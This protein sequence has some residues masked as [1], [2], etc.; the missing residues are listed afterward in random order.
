MPLF[1]KAAA[2]VLISE[3]EDSLS[4]ELGGNEADT[5]SPEDRNSLLQ[6][7]KERL[8][9][10]KRSR[11]VVKRKIT[12]LLKNILELSSSEED[13]QITLSQLEGVRQYLAEVKIFDTKIEEIISNCSLLKYDSNILDE[14]II[15]AS[16]YHMRN[17]KLLLRMT[18]D[19]KT[20]SLSPASEHSRDDSMSRVEMQNILKNIQAS[21]QEIKIPAIKCQVFKGEGDRHSFRSFL[22]SFQNI[23]GVRKDV[24]DAAK[25]QYLKS[26][27][28][29]N[30]LKDIEHLPN[31]D[32]N[33]EVA[34]DILKNLY[35]DESY[36]IDSLFHKIDSAPNLDNK[37]LENIPIFLSEVRANLHELKEFGLNFFDV[38]SA[39]CKLMSHIIVDKLPSNFLRELKLLTQ[40]EY[41]SLNH[42]LDNYGRVLKSTEKGRVKN[43]ASLKRKDIL[44]VGSKVRMTKS[45]RLIM[46]LSPLK[47]S[48]RNILKLTKDLKYFEMKRGRKSLLILLL[49]NVN[50]V[51]GNIE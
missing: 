6:E 37:N 35:L 13:I 20:C 23:Y 43:Q 50:F 47:R 32:E 41:P 14:E 29:G 51:K 15:E 19:Q 39:G 21:K 9:P 1:D 49:Q 22:L 3:L 34:L 26:L 31:V 11:A 12:L 40:E 2:G 5:L 44:N 30:A 17:E 24:T 27:L 7:L 8:S 48:R 18:P 46:L 42:I 38:S 25:L 33:L 4:G 28:E 10:V 45:Q 16:H 36:I